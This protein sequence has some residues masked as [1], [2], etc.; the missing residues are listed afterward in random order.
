MDIYC[1]K[2]SEPWDLSELHTAVDEGSAADYDDARRTFYADGCGTLFN[3]RPCRENRTL[4]S[5][6]SLVLADVLG[7][8]LDGVAAMLEDAEFLGWFE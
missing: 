6:A 8:D 7:E 4:R 1:P 2:C 3:S 5:E